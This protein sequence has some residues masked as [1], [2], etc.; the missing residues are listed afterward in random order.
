MANVNFETNI[1]RDGSHDYM[2]F[3]TD[4]R[5]YANK[6]RKLAEEHPDEVKIINDDGK[7][8]YA[9]LP[10]NWFKMPSPPIKRNLTEEQRKAASERFKAMREAKS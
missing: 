6:L 9:H 1:L 7:Y 2:E 5:K 3:G 8:V 4:E 10:L